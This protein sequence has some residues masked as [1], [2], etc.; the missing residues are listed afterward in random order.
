MDDQHD[1]NAGQDLQPDLNHQADDHQQGGEE[2]HEELQPE[3]HQEPEHQQE[4]V[5]EEE[6]KEVISPAGGYPSDPTGRISTDAPSLD[7]SDN[8]SSDTPDGEL[9]EVK[10]KT[11]EELAPIVDQLD[12]PA[13]EKFG[14]IM[15][16]IQALNDKSLVEKAYAT[17]HQI[18][19]D[20]ARA[21]ALFD[22]VNE[23]NYFTHPGEENKSED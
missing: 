12:L 20:H 21:Q 6:N 3:T 18:E 7:L 2:H 9:G 16:I 5:Q 4:H 13:E 23:I 17:A 1:E 10:H 8:P 14:V 22:I 11:L 15:M 19:D